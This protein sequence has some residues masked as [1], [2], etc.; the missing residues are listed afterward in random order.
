ML[1]TLH[2]FLSTGILFRTIGLTEKNAESWEDNWS[3]REIRED[4]GDR[5]QNVPR[6]SNITELQLTVV[7]KQNTLRVTL[8]TSI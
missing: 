4:G 5:N 8:A 2:C 3:G 7:S 1:L 6:L